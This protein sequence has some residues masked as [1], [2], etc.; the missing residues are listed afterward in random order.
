MLVILIFGIYLFAKHI[1]FLSKVI[2]FG[3]NFRQAEGNNVELAD[4]FNAY[5]IYNKENYLFSEIKSIDEAKNQKI[6]MMK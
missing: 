2:Y 4:V 6:R 5:G 1:P 3:S